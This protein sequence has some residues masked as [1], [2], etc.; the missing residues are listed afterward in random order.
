PA[1]SEQNQGIPKNKNKGFRACDGSLITYL[2]GDDYFFPEKI[3]KELQIFHSNPNFDIVYSNFMF[4][5]EHHAPIKTW[6]DQGVSAPQGDVFEAIFSKQFPHKTLYRN[7]L[8]KSKVL[9]EIGYY[10][11]H[12]AAYHDWDSRIRMS[13]GRYIGYSDYVGSAYV[14]DPRGISKTTKRNRLIREM[15]FVIEKNSPLL[16]DL[17]SRKKA[18]IIKS[19]ET[20]I[21]KKEADINPHL[22]NPTSIKYLMQSG[23]L[24]YL[25]KV[26]KKSFATH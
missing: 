22:F 8:I 20:I 16:N 3:E 25:K 5:D 13:K 17:P 18:E 14:E 26:I 15:R 2:D 11:E 9:H 6:L 7:E 10:D 19:I 1:L 23:D 12:I 21:S 4:V 24:T